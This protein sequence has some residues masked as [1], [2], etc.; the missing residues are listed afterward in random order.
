MGRLNVKE[1]LNQANSLERKIRILKREIEKM[2]ILASS[3]GAVKYDGER[4]QS[5]GP[6]DPLA[7]TVA[8]IMEREKILSDLIAEYLKKKKLLE[9]QIMMMDS[10]YYADVLYGKYVAGLTFFD[11]AHQIKRERRQ[12]IRIHNKAVSAFKEQYKE[13]FENS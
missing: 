13:L 4:V 2:R 7:V 1:Y 11:L 3:P 9:S 10:S 8:N 5:S 6:N 12:T